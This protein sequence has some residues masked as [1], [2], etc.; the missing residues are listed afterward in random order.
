MDHNGV[1]ASILIFDNANERYTLNRLN[2]EKL[3]NEFIKTSTSNEM[4]EMHR[5][6]D[7]LG[8]YQ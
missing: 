7:T 1:Y 5:M 6:F 2:D 8:R 3:N 4:M